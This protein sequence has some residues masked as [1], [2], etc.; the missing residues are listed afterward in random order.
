MG[1]REKIQINPTGGE[2]SV[3]L[4]AMHIF[5]ECKI[6]QEK[7]KNRREKIQNL[8]G[9]CHKSEGKRSKMLGGKGQKCWG[10]EVQK[11]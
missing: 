8:E 4:L 1:E 6:Q 9:N 5:S 10:E 2:F 3:Q 11:C 7:V